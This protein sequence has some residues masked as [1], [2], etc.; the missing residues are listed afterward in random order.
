MEEQLSNLKRAMDDTVYKG[1]HFSE[2]DK[3]K[4][5]SAIKHPH[6]KNRLEWFPKLLTVAVFIGCIIFITDLTKKNINSSDKPS[7]LEQRN[8]TKTEEQRN[9][10]DNWVRKT[11]IKKVL[12]Q[13]FTGPDEKL[14]DLLSN[15]KYR[16]VVNNMEENQELDKY[17]AEVYGP[18]FADFSRIEAF[19]GAFGGTKYQS[20]AYMNGYKL[21]LKNITIEQ[22][23]ILYRYTFIA[24]VGY[25]KNGDE[26]KTASVEGEVVFSTKEKEEGKILGFQYVNDNGLSN[27]LSSN[28]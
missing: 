7:Q 6:K 8:G 14:V 4:I 24:K 11:A 15:P 25:Q 19:I 18:Y 13:E 5:R 21:S 22:E 2:E 23:N 17:L 27:I 12:E 28:N 9:N 10:E 1:N 16:T 20:F 3:V 26:E